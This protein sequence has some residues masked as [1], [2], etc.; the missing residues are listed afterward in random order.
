MGSFFASKICSESRHRPRMGL[1]RSSLVSNSG[2][3]IDN[4]IF[5]FTR[6]YAENS[7]SWWEIKPGRRCF[8]AAIRQ[9]VAAHVHAQAF[10]LP[11][12]MQDLL[13]VVLASAWLR[14]PVPHRRRV[15][16]GFVPSKDIAEAI[17]FVLITH[18]SALTTGSHPDTAALS[19]TERMHPENGHSPKSRPLLNPFCLQSVLGGR[20]HAVDIRRLP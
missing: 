8:R 1:P 20:T 5:A 12:R 16:G 11:E 4:R 13:A 3:L 19:N 10:Q 6:L 14:L 2:L 15:S 9:V 18:H 17:G 7:A